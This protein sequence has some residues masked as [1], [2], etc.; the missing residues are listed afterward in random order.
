[1]IGG[2]VGGLY[3]LA[4]LS[5]NGKVEMENLQEIAL[6]SSE[7]ESGYAL[8]CLTRPISENAALDFDT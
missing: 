2:G 7:I 3:T 8:T 5:T 4:Y 1:M 6:D